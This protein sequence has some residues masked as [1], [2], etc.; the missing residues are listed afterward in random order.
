MDYNEDLDP[1]PPQDIFNVF[2]AV[3]LLSQ[4]SSDSDKYKCTWLKVKII[5]SS[6]LNDGGCPDA[7]SRSLS[8]ALNHEEITSIIAA[9]SDIFQRK[10]ANT[11]TQPEQKK[12]L[13][14]ICTIFI[15]T[16]F[17]SVLGY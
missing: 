13:L 4:S 16:S 6:I 1:P 8:I 15:G 14:S 12:K 2:E 10:C 3:Y 17:T 9:T 11:I 7:C 5:R